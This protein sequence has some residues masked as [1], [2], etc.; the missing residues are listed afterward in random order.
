MGLDISALLRMFESM[1]LKEVFDS[2]NER[3]ST[4]VRTRNL[5]YSLL[6]RIIIRKNKYFS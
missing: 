3:L 6:L 2:M 5:Q 1:N 4:N